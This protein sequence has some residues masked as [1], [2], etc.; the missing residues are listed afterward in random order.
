MGELESSPKDE[1]EAVALLIKGESKILPQSFFQVAVYIINAIA[2]S[3]FPP[4]RGICCSDP[5]L[6]VLWTVSES[7][8]YWVMI[9]I[10]KGMLGG[11]GWV[12]SARET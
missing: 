9:C 1:S 7:K 10:C 11:V 2:F 6:C 8:A 3:P 4:N 12:S 5:Q